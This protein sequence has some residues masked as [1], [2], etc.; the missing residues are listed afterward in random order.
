MKP[1][2]HVVV[3]TFG[4]LDWFERGEET[5]REA[6]ESSGADFVIHRHGDN[7][8]QARNL[9]VGDN[10]KFPGLGL[11]LVFL[12]ADDRLCNGYCDILRDAIEAEENGS[13][14]NIL[15]QPQTIAWLGDD[16]YE[17]E[18]NFIPD[19]DMNISN[20]L[21]IGTGLSMDHWIE[22]DPALPAL[23]DW[24]FFL[25]MISLGAKVKQVPGMIYE[26]GVS[27]PNPRNAPGQNQ[28]QAYQAIRN[29]NIR[30][31]NYLWESK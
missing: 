8:A 19:R 21:V 14:A 17:G 2:I 3:A 10:W 24:D 16:K 13:G 6:F 15:Y 5:A 29:K 9:G 28:N 1:S 18:P 7:L 23:E 27:N 26:V 31:S 12:D 20:N 11:H 25:R 30:V 22:F 4:S